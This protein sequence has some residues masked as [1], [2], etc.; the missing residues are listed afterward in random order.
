MLCVHPVKDSPSRIASRLRPGF[1]E[2]FDKVPPKN[3]LDVF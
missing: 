3:P 1:L 2:E